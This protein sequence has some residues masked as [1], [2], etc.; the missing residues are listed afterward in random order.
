MTLLKGPKLLN[1]DK[2]PSKTIMATT[3]GSDENWLVGQF[4]SLYRYLIVSL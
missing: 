2:I 4:G 1:A 3:L